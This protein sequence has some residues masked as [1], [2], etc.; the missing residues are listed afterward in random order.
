MAV[1]PESPSV[2]PG[3]GLLALAPGWQPAERIN[4]GWLADEAD[5][6]QR[7]LAQCDPDADREAAITATASELVEAVRANRHRKSGI[8]AFMHEYD[9]SSEEG[10]VLM[11]LAEAL[12]RIPDA[13]TADRLIADKLAAGDWEEHLGTSESVFVNA[14]TWGLMLTGRLV[15]PGEQA[16]R[17]PGAFLRQ[18]ATR[19]GEPVMRTAM[20]QAMRVMGY[21][22]VLGR[23]ID[24]ALQRAGRGDNRHYRYSFDML[25]EAALTAADAE[26]Y[27]DAYREAIRAVGRSLEGAPGVIAA[28]GISVKLSAL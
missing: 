12:L 10:V 27:H 21:Q 15:R 13:G 2:E 26:A 5:C 24:E 17:R 4:R 6:L 1:T 3:P 7:L 19:L 28:P 8:D 25:G 22:F 9:L 23:D 11:C 20:R 18:M 16:R 14:S